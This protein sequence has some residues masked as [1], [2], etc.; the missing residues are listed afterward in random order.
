LSSFWGPPPFCLIPVTYKLE[1]RNYNGYILDINAFGAYIET[2]E[3]FP[4]GQEI[5][6]TFFNLFSHK[7]MN[8]D[9]KII[10]SNTYGIGVKF[11]DLSRLRYKW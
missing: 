7:N 2:S 4:I 8:L 11:S 1:E 9:G 10:W 3:P 5:N 6:L